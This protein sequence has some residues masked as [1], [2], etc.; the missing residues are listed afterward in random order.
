MEWYLDKKT[1][2]LT[3]KKP[4]W[5]WNMGVVWN[6]AAVHI[7]DQ[8]EPH[9]HATL[10][11]MYNLLN[12]DKNHDFDQTLL[13]F[14]PLQGTHYK[15]ATFDGPSIWLI[16][17]NNTL[18]IEVNQAFGPGATPFNQVNRHSEQLVIKNAPLLW[19]F[20]NALP[21]AFR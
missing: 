6:K 21:K 12:Q 13:S 8:I 7:Q 17:S 20:F 14:K 19:L 5:L 4:D 10:M 2:K 9:N 11:Q 16:Q 18:A 3:Y 15:I 1:L